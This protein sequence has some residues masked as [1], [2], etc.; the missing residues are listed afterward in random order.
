[1]ERFRVKIVM[2]NGWHDDDRSILNPT[3]FFYAIIN[4]MFTER[5]IW[6]KV[7]NMIIVDCR[8]SIFAKARVLQSI[9]DWNQYSITL[10]AIARIDEETQSQHSAPKSD[11]HTRFASFDKP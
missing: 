6:L 1:M 3:N 4:Q 2:A 5:Y 10:Y 11:R 8:N 7:R 9:S